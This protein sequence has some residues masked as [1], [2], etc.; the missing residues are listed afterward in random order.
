M[1]GFQWDFYWCRILLPYKLEISN[2]V[3][4]LRDFFIT[5]FFVILGT[6]LIINQAN[7]LAPAILLSLFVLIGNPLIV[8]ILMG[9]LGYTKRTSFYAG[10]TVAQIS[11]FSLILA[12][13]GL[14]LNHINESIVSLITLVGIITITLSVYMIYH[15]HKLYNFL[16][17]YLNIFE[18]E[19][20][21][22]G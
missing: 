10:L 14:K 16:A 18:K 15:N 19:L 17:P 11:E 1:G 5:L 7:L 8:T 2:K 9:L 6:Q 3:K 21:I 22:E 12:F 20:T 4:P 13:L